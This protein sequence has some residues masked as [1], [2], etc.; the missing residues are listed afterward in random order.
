M[1]IEKEDCILWTHEYGAFIAVARYP[2]KFM[3]ESRI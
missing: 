1:D 2:A 3:E